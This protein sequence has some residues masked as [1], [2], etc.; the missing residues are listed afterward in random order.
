MQRL[1][2]E[3]PPGQPSPAPPAVSSVIWWEVSP[4]DAAAAVAAGTRR[5]EAQGPRP[6]RRARPVGAPEPAASHCA[7]ARPARRSEGAGGQL[8]SGP[9]HPR[10]GRAPSPAASHRSWPPASGSGLR[11]LPGSSLAP[12]T[13]RWRGGSTC[14]HPGGGGAAA[15][16]ALVFLR[17]PPL[18]PRRRKW[19]GM[20][21][22]CAR[23]A[24]RAKEIRLLGALL[25]GLGPV[26]LSPPRPAQGRAPSPALTQGDSSLTGNPP[27]EEPRAQ[28]SP[29][30]GNPLPG[31]E[32]PVQ[33]TPQDR[34]P[35]HTYGGPHI[36]TPPEQETPHPI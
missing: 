15:A 29:H 3:T 22:V 25:P 4:G 10:R 9:P 21:C 27:A 11:H 7:R 26:S 1:D 5:G 14:S 12:P 28:G 33:E 6:G 2:R 20:G 23:R 17:L 18:S 31:E 16:A 8:P 13:P 24:H 35:P 30:R 32:I 34:R 19:R 36:G